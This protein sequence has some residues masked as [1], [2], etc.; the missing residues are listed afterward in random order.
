[1]KISDIP[2]IQAHRGFWT[3]DIS[4]NTLQGLDEASLQGYEMA[5]IDIQ[6]SQDQK[7]VLFHDIDL[8]KFSDASRISQKTAQELFSNYQIELLEQIF[9]KT[10]I[11]YLNIELKVP[12]FKTGGILENQVVT[13]VEKYHWED[14]VLFSSFSVGALYHLR[15]RNPKILRAFLWAKGETWRDL[16]RY[17][18]WVGLI[19]MRPQLLHLC[20]DDFPNLFFRILKFLRIPFAVWTVRSRKQRD[21]Y[22]NLGAVSVIEDANLI[23]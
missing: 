23:R 7:I 10:K 13:L 1:M 20:V 5:E 16:K 15:L 19:W 11:K 14:R 8:Q 22:L 2:K 17:L 3:N 4:E 21:L 18:M 6:L 9:Q 12:V